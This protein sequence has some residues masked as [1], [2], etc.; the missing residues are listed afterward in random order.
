LFVIKILQFVDLGFEGFGVYE[1]DHYC[2]FFL[3]CIAAYSNGKYANE[4]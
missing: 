1:G 4:N 2:H 3:L